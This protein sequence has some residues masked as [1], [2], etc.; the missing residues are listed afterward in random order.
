ML[1][2]QYLTE[3][4]IRRRQIDT[5]KIFNDNVTEVKENSEYRVEFSS[6][7]RNMCLNVIL[8]PDFPN[9]K[10]NIFVNPVFPHPWLAENSNEVMGAPGLVNYTP[11]ADLGRIVQAIIREF[12]RAVPNILSLEDKSTDT[13]PQSQYSI[14]SL[15]FPE[16][17][18]LTI[19]EL[20][21]IMENPDLQVY[22]LKY[23]FNFIQT[24]FDSIF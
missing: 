11:H 21:E 9:E 1:P 16:L 3:Q 23:Y 20:Q 12:Q 15:M 6:D 4:D 22:K 13:S 19:E 17:S 7:G 2:R 5:L 8:P 24:I 14:Q 18:E 10:P